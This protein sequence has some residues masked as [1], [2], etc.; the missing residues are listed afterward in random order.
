MHSYGLVEVSKRIKHTVKVLPTGTFAGTRHSFT[1]QIKHRPRSR[2]NFK[3]YTKTSKII[4]ENLKMLRS[5]C[6]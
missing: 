3:Y 6:G 1:I 4:V 5:S 2:N